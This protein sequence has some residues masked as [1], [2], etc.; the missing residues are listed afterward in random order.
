[1]KLTP[2]WLALC[3]LPVLACGPDGCETPLTLQLTAAQC[4]LNGLPFLS[5]DNDTRTNLALLLADEQAF[6]LPDGALPL[7][8]TVDALI[9]P[10]VGDTGPAGP[11][12]LLALA[13]G[14]G[15]EESTTQAALERAAGWSEG[16]CISNNPVS[17]EAFLLALAQTQALTASDR[18]Q[19]ASQ[20][21][22]MLGQCGQPQDA[23]Q[24]TAQD[25]SKP[26]SLS[27]AAQGFADYLTASRHFYQGE[28]AQADALFAALAGQD[29]PWLKETAD[30]MR[31]RVALN[32]SQQ[33]AFDDWGTLDRNQID[34]AAVQRS[35]QLI[36]DYRARYPKGR[37]L[38][39]ATGLLRRLAWFKGDKELLASHYLQ[40]S[41][42]QSAPDLV[43]EIDLKLLMQPGFTGSVAM[44]MLTLVQDLRR[45][46]I[47][48]SWDEWQPLQAAELTQQTS[49]FASNPAWLAYLQ[50]A[51]RYYL[52][53]D[54]DAVVA[55]APELGA[56][57]LDNLAFSQQVLKGM[58]LAAR[59]AWPAAEQQ[60]RALLANQPT[61]LQDQLLQLALAMTL[62]RAGQLEQIFA[63]ESPI[64]SDHYRIPLL[65]YV[66]PA[67][68][69]RRMAR[70]EQASD[71]LRQR[72]SHTLSYKQ[73]THGDYRG[74]LQDLAGSPATAPFDWQ[75]S[76]GYQCPALTSVVTTLAD[77]PRSP[78]ALNCLGEFF[79]AQGLDWDPLLSRPGADTLAGSPDLFAGKQSS[80]LDWYQ[81]VIANPKAARE[82]KAYALYR[83]INC[84]APSGSNG[85][86][87]Q[88]VSVNQRKAWFNTLKQQHGTSQ[89]AKQLKYYW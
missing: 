60:W 6:S 23:D 43:N 52:A 74:F 40:A 58:A 83:A 11:D 59:Q 34:K 22:A 44:P 85:C 56:G 67:P 28:F 25:Q 50:Q 36:G 69:L 76:Q 29:Q 57:H 79:L 12:P 9:S 33:S 30:Y 82:E 1:M 17:A 41:Q 38:D 16:R 88:Q 66:A 68:L 42:R 10:A 63:K 20:R 62:E 31:I 49:Q 13:A 2:L 18:S 81:R 73:L 47:H 51:E 89:W 53:K 24:G 86:G 61:P 65:E 64:R 26:A 39:S 75:G 45:L 19:L 35:E 32:L 46:R 4:H 8:F 80:R 87:S 27:P 14:L 70:D 37:Y 21:L 54:Y 15:I 71:T 7:P 84:Y 78:K 72:A 48:D 55:A 5:P 77:N 3:S